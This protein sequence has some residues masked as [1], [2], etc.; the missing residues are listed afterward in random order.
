MK[1]TN[2][3]DGIGLVQSIKEGIP[4]GLNE[5]KKIILDIGFHCYIPIT[6]G[7]VI[8]S[9]N[10]ESPAEFENRIKPRAYIRRVALCTKK[11]HF[12]SRNWR[13]VN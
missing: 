6:I 1:H 10:Q 5:L 9:R 8:L 11:L 7:F 4:F 3:Q 12:V 13:K 2:P